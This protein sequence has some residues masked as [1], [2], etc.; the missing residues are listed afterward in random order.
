MSVLHVVFKVDGQEVA[1]QELAYHDEKQFT[2]EA[3]FSWSPSEHTM[4]LE[5]EPTVLVT[6]DGYLRRAA[7]TAPE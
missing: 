6:V 5:L 1:K 2:F 3:P 4:V 7:V